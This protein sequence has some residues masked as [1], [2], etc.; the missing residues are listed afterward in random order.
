MDPAYADDLAQLLV[1]V[2]HNYL[3]PK[4]ARE[5]DELR[6]V[7]GD[8]PDPYGLRADRGSRRGGQWWTCFF[9]FTPMIF[10]AP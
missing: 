8:D 7:D 1:T 6:Q 4:Q 5:T 2:S 3:S 10:S 9:L